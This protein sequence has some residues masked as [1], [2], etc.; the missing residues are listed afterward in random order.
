MS[1]ETYLLVGGSSSVETAA[2]PLASVRTC[3]E[4]MAVLETSEH[5]DAHDCKLGIRGHAAQDVPDIMDDKQQ[6]ATQKR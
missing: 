4:D 5:Q 2:V 1:S 3:F 6:T